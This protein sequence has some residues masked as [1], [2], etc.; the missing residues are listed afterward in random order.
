MRDGDEYLDP[1]EANIQ[2]I[3]RCYN[4]PRQGNYNGAIAVD[5][6]KK[7]AFVRYM[8]SRIGKRNKIF[9]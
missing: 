1:N 4:V 7:C 5:R 3:M 8:L 6:P 2:R 9:K